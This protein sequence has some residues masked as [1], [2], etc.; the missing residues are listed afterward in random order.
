MGSESILSCASMMI[1]DVEA[2]LTEHSGQ[3][4]RRRLALD[5]D[6]FWMKHNVDDTGRHY[7]LASRQKHRYFSEMIGPFQPKADSVN[8]AVLDE[9]EIHVHRCLWMS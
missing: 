6:V 3:G 8:E 2:V 5:R 7:E 1:E 4:F 9:H